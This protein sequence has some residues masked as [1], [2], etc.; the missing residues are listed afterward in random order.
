M[1]T[2]TTRS[3]KLLR[4]NGWT[5]VEKVERPWN[6]HTRRTQD[7]FKFADIIAVRGS[8]CLLVQTTSGSNMAARRTKIAASA[9]AA[10]WLLPPTRRIEIHGWVLRGPRGKRKKWECRVE[11]VTGL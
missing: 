1:P 8:E 6:P 9:Q 4:D 2:P 7:L 10:F 3:L 5:L 11:D